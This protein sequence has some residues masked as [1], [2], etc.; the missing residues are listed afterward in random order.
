MSRIAGYWRVAGGGAQM[1]ERMAAPLPDEQARQQSHASAE[2]GAVCLDPAVAPNAER[3]A[4]SE[5]G[6]VVVGMSGHLYGEGRRLRAEPARHCLE[7]Y[8]RRGASFARHLNGTFTVAISDG[9][10][11]LLRLV[12]D[13]F[14]SRAFYFSEAAGGVLFASS[15]RSILAC[16]QA[17]PA[18]DGDAI[19]EFLI[20]GQLLGQATYYPTIRH[21]PP[22]S[23]MTFGDRSVVES[24]WQPQFD[25]DA[26]EPL[27]ICAARM[28]EAIRSAVRDATTEGGHD[29]LMLS[30]GLDSRMIAAAS[31]RPLTCVTLHAV[32]AIEAPLARRVAMTLGYEH[33][34]V[35]LADDFPLGLLTAGSLVGDG[36]HPF[37]Q[38]QPLALGEAVRELALGRLYNGWGM[39]MYLAGLWMPL[40]P[41]GHGPAGELRADAGEYFL[42]GLEAPDAAQLRRL[43]GADRASDALDRVRAKLTARYRECRARAGNLHDAIALAIVRNFSRFPHYLNL[44]A[45]SCICAEAAPMHD[46]RLI[47]AFLRTPYRHRF[48]ARAYR[49]ALQVIDPRMTRIP[50][51]G[52]GVPVYQ[53]DYL[54]IAAS[55]LQRKVLRRAGKLWHALKGTPE[56]MI[57]SAWPDMAQTMRHH[58]NWHRTLRQYASDSWLV[59]N[60]LAEGQGLTGLIEDHIAG[61][62]DASRLLA[63]W[64]T[65]EVWFRHYG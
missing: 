65:L 54:Q 13:R 43:L 4:A 3:I 53:N 58:P 55:Y 45:L 42:E 29:G 38:A 52:T 47:D 59:S 16:A 8:L 34:F 61:R 40:A 60:G 2:F 41:W 15:V 32:E 18:T 33:R 21:L 9:R 23:V 10:E 48:Y 37:D 64:L 11:E 49:R 27:E 7:L 28:A 19:H 36:M 63:N 14:N 31:P 17:Q 25:A 57:K 22:A 39:D 6:E 26:Q 30:G 5:D 1:L 50:Y 56:R 12:T 46:V 62:H 24:Y 51:S 44:K 20:I 35:R